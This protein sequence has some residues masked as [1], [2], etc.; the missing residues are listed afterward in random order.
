MAKGYTFDIWD[1]LLLFFFLLGIFLAYLRF[2]PDATP[3]MKTLGEAGGALMTGI[4]F[5][6]VTKYL[7]KKSL[8]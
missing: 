5:A 1:L 8:R 3:I 4:L 6:F 7:I 2:L